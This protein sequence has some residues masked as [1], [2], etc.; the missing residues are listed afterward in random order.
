[1]T[2]KK[3]SILENRK[4][5]FLYYYNQKLSDREIGEKM[6]VFRKT[7]GVYR[8]FLKL[9][10]NKKS[11]L[12]LLKKSFIELYEIGLSDGQIADKLKFSRSGI[13]KYRSMLGLVPNNT[14]SENDKV[15]IKDLEKLNYSND[16]INVLIGQTPIKSN[17]EEIT[18]REK[19]ILIGILLGDGNIYKK[20]NSTKNAIFSTS[21]S[22]NQ[23]LY[24][25]HIA[26]VLMRLGARLHFSH[27][28]TPDKRNNKYYESYI[29]RLKPSKFFN[30]LY[31]IFYKN[32]IKTIPD[33]IYNYYTSESLAYQ[34]M[35]DG[36]KICGTY[37]IATNCFSISELQKFQ[38]FLLTK[39]NLKTTLHKDNGIYIRKESANIFKELVSPYI[40]DSMKYKLY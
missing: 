8:Q 30:N 40:I 37:K 10:P 33:Y 9:P 27:S 1:M 31:N 14:I 39:F 26:T 38:Y 12:S 36:S 34:Y 6:G 29:V 17:I 5:E 13:S 15:I 21:H 3:K 7:V 28:K 24:S 19:A 35:D 2:L 11:P 18:D 32:G 23:K 22:S 20:E 4:E 16:V 25:I